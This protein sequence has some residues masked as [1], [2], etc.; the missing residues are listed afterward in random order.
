VYI[1]ALALVDVSIWH[2][3]RN[4]LLWS[5][6]FT[7][8]AFLVIN[9][10]LLIRFLDPVDPQAAKLEANLITQVFWLRFD[11]KLLLGF[12]FSAL[13]ALYLASVLRGRPL[14]SENEPSP[15]AINPS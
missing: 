1:L 8:T 12:L 3:E 15:Q 9:N 7:A 14:K 4:R 5:L 10:F 13:T 11:A 2:P 6:L